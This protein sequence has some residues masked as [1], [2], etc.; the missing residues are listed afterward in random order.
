VETELAAQGVR[1]RDN[2]TQMNK[3]LYTAGIDPR[4]KATGDPR[5]DMLLKRFGYDPR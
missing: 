4:I 3:A 5:A 2:E 1:I